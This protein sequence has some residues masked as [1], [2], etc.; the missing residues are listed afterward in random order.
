MRASC[1][2]PWAI[3]LC[4]LVGCQKEMTPT[5]I[6]YQ[7]SSAGVTVNGKPAGRGQTIHTRDEVV[8]STKDSFC[9]LKLTD[10]SKIFLLPDPR[11]GSTTFSLEGLKTQRSSKVLLMRLVRGLLALIVPRGRSASETLEVQASYTTT[12]IKGTQLR[13]STGTEGDQVAVREGQ[14][15][16]RV[17]D[18]DRT[19]TL[20]ANQQVSYDTSKMDLGQVEAYNPATE[21]AVW[22]EQKGRVQRSLTR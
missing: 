10:G 4:L 9:R 12:A 22:Q 19:R 20:E 7:V 3:M 5:A 8:C 16:V 14:V 2:V 18:S 17:T 21:E 15:E 13:I 11:G 1:P 6:I